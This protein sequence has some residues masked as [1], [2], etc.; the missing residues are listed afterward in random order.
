MLMACRYDCS[1][2]FWTVNTAGQSTMLGSVGLRDVR[3]D[4]A[5]EHRDAL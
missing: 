1:Q 3:G 2:A 5:A 4:R